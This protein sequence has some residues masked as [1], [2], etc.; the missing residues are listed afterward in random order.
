MLTHTFWDS[1]THISG[2]MVKTIPALSAVFQ[3][4]G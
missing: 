4:G 3:V 1:F 2:D